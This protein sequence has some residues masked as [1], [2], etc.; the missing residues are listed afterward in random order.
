MRLLVD[1]HAFLWFIIDSP[2]LS[3]AARRLL[4]SPAHERFISVASIWE[5]T[6]KHSLGKLQLIRGLAVFMNDIEQAN[7]TTL[8]IQSGHILELG[9]LPFHHRDPFDRMLI[10]QAKHEGMHLPTADRAFEPYDVPLIAA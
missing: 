8:P 2:R 9:A 7:F 5:V 3:P 4:I 10:A 1:T 6:I